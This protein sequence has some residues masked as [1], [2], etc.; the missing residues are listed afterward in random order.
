MR[1]SKAVQTALKEKQPVVCL[2]TTIISHGMPYPKNVETALAVEQVIRDL[3]VIPATIGIIDGEPVIGM[4][5]AEISE[6]GQRQGIV[7]A[8]RA[9]LPIV[10]AKKLWAST[11]V[12]ATMIL[13]HKAGIEVFVTG[14]IGGVHRDYLETMDLSTDLEELALTNVSV[15]CS[16]V[17]SILDIPK[18]LE[19]LET[20]GVPV[21]GYQT[22]DFPNFFT[23]A[24]GAKVMYRVDTPDEVAQVI[25]SKR[26]YG[27]QGGILIA[28]PIPSSD[29]LDSERIEK[30]IN[31]A[32]KTSQMRN[33]HGKAVTPFLLNEIDQLTHS[34]SLKANIALILNNAA[35]GAQIAMALSKL[36]NEA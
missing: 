16:G 19:Y 6:F 34:E 18:T 9:D 23:T 15:V 11:T 4:N 13:A 26:D 29:S 32:L 10:F 12:S 7:K 28:N 31:N 35:V 14:G 30:V 22:N 24:S 36:K 1:I 21:L 33:V 3:G 20:K 5:E 17:K 8:S 27:L 25:K 2:E